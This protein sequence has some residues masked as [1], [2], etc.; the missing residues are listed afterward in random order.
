MG[1][2]TYVKNQIRNIGEMEFYLLVPD[3]DCE[4]TDLL[5]FSSETDLEEH[6]RENPGR[7]KEG[8]VFVCDLKSIVLSERIQQSL[9]YKGMDK[10]VPSF[11]NL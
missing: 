9:W 7:Y 3:G 5:V 11:E 2:R 8:C 10:S 6:I 1:I 4:V